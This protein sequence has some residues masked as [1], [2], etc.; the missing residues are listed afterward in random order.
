MIANAEGLHEYRAIFETN[1]RQL[2]DLLA[3]LNKTAAPQTR[4]EVQVCELVEALV[5]HLLWKVI[6]GVYQQ[7]AVETTQLV[8]QCHQEESNTPEQ[9][10]GSTY[11][12]GQ[13]GNSDFDVNKQLK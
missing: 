7:V 6:D 5:T 2:I 10:S 13:G 3:N 12:S 8:K 1:N 4:Q 9:G 11:H